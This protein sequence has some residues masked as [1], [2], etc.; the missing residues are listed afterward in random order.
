MLY[1]KLPWIN[2][3]RDVLK[4]KILKTEYTT[5]DTVS[6]SA[7]ELIA[8]IL[9]KDPLER[10]NIESLINDEWLSDCTYQITV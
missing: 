1:G 7:N 4:E 2:R 10:P 3:D 6:D 8:R 5:N 9:E